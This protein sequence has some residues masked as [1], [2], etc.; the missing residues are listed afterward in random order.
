MQIVS[1]FSGCGGL[2]L[3]F[4]YAGFDVIWANEF[5][6]T[7]H[8]TYLYN[9]RNFLDL[10]DIRKIDSSEIP[11][12]LGIIGGPPCQSWSHG[13]TRAGINHEKGKLFYEYVRILKDKQP[14][15][16][17]IE[18]VSGIL[19]DR[20]KSALNHIIY[21]LQDAGYVLSIRLLDA[22]YY[23]VPQERKRVFILGYRLDVNAR[24]KFPD[25][26]SYFVSLKDAIADLQ[27]KPFDSEYSHEYLDKDYSGMYMAR[28]RVR[29]WHELSFTIPASG[30]HVPLHPQSKPMI[31]VGRDQFAFDMT[32]KPYR[33]LTVR[34]AA[35]IQTF[36]DDFT[37][38]YKNIVDGYK[39]VGNAVPVELAYL[40]ASQIRIN[41]G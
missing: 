1:L 3:G 19:S 14:L 20:H 22:A 16:F 35:R 17:L 27:Y 33:R 15:F 8:E 18:N 34:E 36:P 26:A 30:R 21:L 13:G 24:M 40:L 2:D 9:H 31:K 23:G 5:D 10:R 29:Q 6:K 28:N 39:M 12:C 25:T 11:N 32:S 7:I 41:L 4:K 37:F 38:K